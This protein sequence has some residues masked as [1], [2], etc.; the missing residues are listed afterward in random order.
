MNPAP[1]PQHTHRVTGTCHARLVHATRRLM[2]VTQVLVILGTIY[3][4]F[5]L[6]LLALDSD[7]ISHVE[8]PRDRPCNPMHTDDCVICKYRNACGHSLGV[9]T[10]W[11]SGALGTADAALPAQPPRAAMILARPFS[12]GPPQ[13]S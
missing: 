3:A 13:L 8:S 9:A 11:A 10:K 2:F 5:R 1:A 6:Q 4:D 7:H 12:R